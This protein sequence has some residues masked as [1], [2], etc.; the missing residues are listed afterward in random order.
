MSLANCLKPP[1]GIPPKPQNPRQSNLFII[2]YFYCILKW[3]FQR[4]FS[5]KPRLKRR[6]KP[7][8]IKKDSRESKKLQKT[9]RLPQQLCSKTPR[10]HPAARSCRR[11]VKLSASLS[12]M[13]LQSQWT[14]I[15]RDSRKLQLFPRINTRLERTSTPVC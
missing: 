13:V 1:V 4:K 9:R 11:M 14:L 12:I 15:A 6:R 2:N 7:K 10:S 8:K 5:K 3:L